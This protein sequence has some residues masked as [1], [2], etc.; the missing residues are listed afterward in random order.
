MDELLKKIVEKISSYDIF[1]N[2]YPGIL[3]SYVLKLMFNINLLLGNWI[4]NLI[5]LYFIG[6]ILSRIGSIVVEPLLKKFKIIQ[7]MPYPD[8][9]TA[10]KIDPFIIKL[11]EVNN[12]YRTLLSTFL[13]VTICKVCIIGY[14]KITFF[15]E[16]TDWLLLILLILIILLFTLS[17]RKQTSYVKKRITSALKK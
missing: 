5:A 11:S 2:L 10:S 3:F 14:N 7:Y 15:Q 4:E 8:Y 6:M 17:Y 1:N 9:V 12:I 13:C 16:N